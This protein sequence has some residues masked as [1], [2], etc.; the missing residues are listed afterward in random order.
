MSKTTTNSAR[1]GGP[2]DPQER[3][4]PGHDGQPTPP[5]AKPL[6]SRGATVNITDDP[7]DHDPL[8]GAPIP[9]GDKDYVADSDERLLKPVVR[10]PNNRTGGG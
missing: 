7:A 8:A 10:V 4:R 9:K 5:E 1:P 6:P 2:D 3:R